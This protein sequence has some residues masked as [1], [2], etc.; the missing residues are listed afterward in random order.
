MARTSGFDAAEE[1]LC[2]ASDRMMEELSGSPEDSELPFLA[3]G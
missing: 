1:N 2:A 3:D